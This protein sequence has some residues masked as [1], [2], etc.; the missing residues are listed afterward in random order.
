MLSVGVKLIEETFDIGVLMV[1]L[2]GLMAFIG[3]LLMM[4]GIRESKKIEN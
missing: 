3:F 1:I 2:Y 4:K